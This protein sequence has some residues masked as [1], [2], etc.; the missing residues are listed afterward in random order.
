MRPRRVSRDDQGGGGRGGEGNAPRRPGTGSLRR[1]I[2]AAS[3]EALRAFG[4]GRVYVEKLIENARHIEI[5]VLG[6][7]HG[8]LVH[9]GEREC[10]VQRR[11][12]KV[13]EESPSPLM[14]S[15]PEMRARMGEAAVKAARAA[16]YYNAGTVEFL[17]D[18]HGQLLFSGNE[19]AAAG[20]ASGDGT[21]HRSRSGAAADRDR[22]G[23]AAAFHAGSRSRCAARRSNAGFMPK[24]RRTISS[25]RRGGSRS[26]QSRPVRVCASIRES[27]RGGTCLWITIRCWRS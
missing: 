15:N 16:G 6:D 9:L 23:R 26:W 27:T 22:G 7:R 5:Q 17:A 18:N 20:G 19:H 14:A 10:S 2:E 24:I 1:R 4:D 13:I 3:S 21:G 12:Q 8:N 11:H 25:R